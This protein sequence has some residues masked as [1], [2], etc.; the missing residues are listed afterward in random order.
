MRKNIWILKINTQDKIKNILQTKRKKIMKIYF[1][2][3]II[4]SDINVKQKPIVNKKIFY[5]DVKF[6]IHII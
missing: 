4:T 5:A 2:L 3:G 1:I 6:H